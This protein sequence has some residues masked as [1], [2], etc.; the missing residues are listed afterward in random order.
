M[1]Q[2]F[3]IMLDPRK[4]RI[5]RDPRGIPVL[6]EDDGEKIIYRVVRAFP[7]SSP[8]AY[9]SLLDDDGKEIG[10]IQN[11]SELD[12]SSMEVIGEELEKAYF[13]P[14][15]KKILMLKELYG[16]VT[17][18]SVETD[19]GFRDFEIRGRDAI[20]LMGLSRVIITDVD[21]NKYEIP[22]NEVLDPRSRSL[23]GWMV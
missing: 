4:I 13:I 20:R 11:L 9:I 8:H 1:A 17:E 2:S 14:R 12:P 7:L 18:F 5:T 21:G 6:Q 22:D 19:R 16:G 15:I 23:L 10:M 3:Q